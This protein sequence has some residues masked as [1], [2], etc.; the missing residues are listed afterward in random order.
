VG[1]SLSDDEMLLKLD[2]AIALARSARP[3]PKLW[4]HRVEL[5]GKLGVK[6]YI[7]ALGGALLAKAT[8]PRVDSLTQD[9]DAGPRGYALR[10][11]AEFLAI[12]NQGR[13]HL[14]ANKRWPLNNRPFLGGPQRIDDFTKIKPKARPAYELFLDCVTDLNRLSASEAL[15][16]FAAFMRIR[17]AVAK[18]EDAASREALALRSTVSAD[19]L[20][21]VCERFIR[22]QPEGGRRGQAFAAAVLDC[23]FPYVR[24]QPINDPTPGDVRLLREDG[25][26]VLPVEVKQ[27]PVDE[28]TALELA[29]TARE[30]GSD[31]ALLLVLAD[32]HSP[33]DREAVRRRALRTYGVMLEVC[34]S[35][36]EFVGAISV[37]G[38]G[39]TQQIL[40]RL[41]GEYAERMR[42]HEVSEQGQRRWRDLV[43]ARRG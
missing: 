12:H 30:A 20:L 21:G 39:M 28:S 25:S 34:E 3:S 24:L 41:P 16:A 11:A 32:R 27:A 13:Y 8:D 33:I 35:V 7:A 37:F 17:M 19:E 26:T 40:D 18:E 4:I 31:A 9:E 14:G 29:A 10:K 22:E 5:L 1:I 23:V 38:G 6:T 36:R 42:E 15:E 2:E 43:E